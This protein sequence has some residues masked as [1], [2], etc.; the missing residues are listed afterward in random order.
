MSAQ[1]QA[2]LTSRVDGYHP[3][4][5]LAGPEEDESS[6]VAVAPARLCRRGRGGQVPKPSRVP[7]GGQQGVK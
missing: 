7:R 2:D 1:T 3:V 5:A 6:G 4:P